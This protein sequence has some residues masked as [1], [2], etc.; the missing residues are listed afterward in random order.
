MTNKAFMNSVKESLYKTIFPALVYCL[1]ILFIS[2]F[3]HALLYDFEDEAQEKDWNITDGEGGIRDGVFEL[4]GGAEGQA[5]VG[6]A[7]WTDY[8][9]TCKVKFF[10]ECAGDTDAGIMYRVKD[11]L[12][13]YIYDFNLQQGFIWAARINGDYIQLGAGMTAPMALESDKWYELKVEVKGDDT[14]AYVDGEEKLAFSHKQLQADAKLDKG[15]VG[16]RIWNSHAM[17]DDFDVNGPGIQ[18]SPVLPAGKLAITW[19]CLRY[20]SMGAWQEE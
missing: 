11:A 19:G 7:N 17:F 2:S 14:I 8:T 3:A 20:N 9:I 4:Q 5:I 18:S 6:D 15:A 12:T 10:P 16:I 1:S 13:H